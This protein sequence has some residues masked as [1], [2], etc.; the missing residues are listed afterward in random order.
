MPHVHVGLVHLLVTAA[1]LFLIMFFA[2][3]FAVRHPDSQLG[4]AV[5]FVL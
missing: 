2:R 3:T 5:A 1:E 4:K